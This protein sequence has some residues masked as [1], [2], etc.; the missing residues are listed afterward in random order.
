MEP[1]V[2]DPKD[3][4]YIATA[5]ESLDYS[6]ATVMIIYFDGSRSSCLKRRTKTY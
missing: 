1:Q 3:G 5:S 6:L 4:D 2:S